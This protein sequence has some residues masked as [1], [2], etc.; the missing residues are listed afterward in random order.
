MRYSGFPEINL[1]T[2]LVPETME[3]LDDIERIDII[4]SGILGTG[5]LTLDDFHQNTSFQSTFR[6]YFQKPQ[7][8]NVNYPQ[9]E[10]LCTIAEGLTHSNTSILQMKYRKILAVA[11][12]NA[13]RMKEIK[14]A[15]ETAGDST[16]SEELKKQFQFCKMAK[17][18]LSKVLQIMELAK[19]T[20]E[21][22]K[23]EG[24]TVENSGKI[25]ISGSIDTS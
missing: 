9:Q 23:S 8:D 25:I 12:E 20:L 1:K 14:T 3:R 16:R 21:S 2:Q 17:A 7:Y 6:R 11:D 5:I 15:I 19:P 22:I 10:K 13:N 24:E 18:I 4:R